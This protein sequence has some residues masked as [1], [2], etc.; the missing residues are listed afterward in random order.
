VA[1]GV[2]AVAAAAAAVA[3]PL[4]LT[5][6]NDAGVAEPG[7]P[8]E[9]SVDQLRSA[10]KETGHHVYWAGAI[11]GRTLELTENERGDVFV[12]YLPAGARIGDRRPDF[13]TVAT[14]PLRRAY[15]QTERSGE[16]KD[17]V[18]RTAPGGGIALWSK[19]RPTSVYFA[20]PGSA[21]LVEVYD[22]SATRARRLAR[23]G[24]VGP[25]R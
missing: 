2:V 14:Y 1:A 16:R 19:S 5:G 8:T 11:R 4:L 12:R 7:V 18:R 21:H 3:V 15:E 25:I 20:Y 17:A 6:E 22:P 23:S 9:V 24:R 10:A 13:T